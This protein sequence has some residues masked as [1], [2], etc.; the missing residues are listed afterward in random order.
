MEAPKTKRKVNL[1]KLKAAVEK[2]NKDF[3]EIGETKI[4]TIKYSNGEAIFEGE[5]DSVNELLN[6]PFVEEV[7]DIVKREPKSKKYKNT[8][9]KI[10]PKLKAPLDI[11]NEDK[12]WTASKMREQMKLY[13]T[14]LKW[15]KSNGKPVWWP[16]SL[17]FEKFE[18]YSYATMRQNKLILKSILEHFDLDPTVHCKNPEMPVVKKKGKTAKK[19]DTINEDSDSE[20]VDADMN[21]SIDGGE[22][23]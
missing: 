1:S 16:T 4:I 20:A 14:T 19:K 5:E 21:N 10:L 15:K 17:S 22:K 6:K 3:V 2:A 12:W 11:E 13:F 7:K 18:H 23:R 8:K 9:E